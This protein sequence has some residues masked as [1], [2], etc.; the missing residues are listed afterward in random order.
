[1]SVSDVRDWMQTPCSLPG[2]GGV[3]CGSVIGGSANYPKP[4]IGIIKAAVSL[5]RGLL[6]RGRLLPVVAYPL[7]VEC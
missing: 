5:P 6:L 2:V 7:C 3:G 1:M 4:E